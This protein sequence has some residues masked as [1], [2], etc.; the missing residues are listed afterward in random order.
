MEIDLNVTANG[1]TN[2]PVLSPWPGTNKAIV[3]AMYPRQVWFE[4]HQPSIFYAPPSNSNI[5]HIPLVN[6]PERD[7]PSSI[8]SALPPS[9]PS[10]C[11]GNNNNLNPS[12]SLYLS[13]GHVSMMLSP[14][15]PHEPPVNAP[16]LPSA[17][18][19]SST[20]PPPLV[21]FDETPVNQE[22]VITRVAS[23]IFNID[24]IWD[25]Q[26]EAINVPLTTSYSTRQP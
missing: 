9:Q 23:Q 2:P 22:S 14:Q 10:P 25:W 18:A 11:V 1:P 13:D 3:H 16:S 15:S 19:L 7:L 6:Q 20:P 26:V 21:P 8:L 5:R 24:T 12:T 17:S 4:E